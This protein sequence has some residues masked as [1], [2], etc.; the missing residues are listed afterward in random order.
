MRKHDS[1]AHWGTSQVEK[2]RGCY[3]VGLGLS[4][5]LSLSACGQ[6]S[7]GQGELRSVLKLPQLGAWKSLGGPI[8][9]RG[10]GDG[11]SHLRTAGDQ[12]PSSRILEI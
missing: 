12:T 10:L 5:C 8:K 9:P 2:G 3:T 1:G 4:V 6:H 7:R 11:M